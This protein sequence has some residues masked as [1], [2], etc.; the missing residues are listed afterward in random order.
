[1][2]PTRAVGPDGFPALFYQNY[3][4]TVHNPIEDMVISFWENQ[5]DLAALNHT[6]HTLIPK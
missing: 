2:G 5:L 6:F 3:W 4:S 1:M